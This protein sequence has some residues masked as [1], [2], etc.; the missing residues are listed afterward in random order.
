MLATSKICIAIEPRLSCHSMQEF[1]VD[2]TDSDIMN[3]LLQRNRDSKLSQP[4]TSPMVLANF[5]SNDRIVV[6]LGVFRR[7]SNRRATSSVPT[8][9]V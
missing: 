6:T 8:P 5:L 4:L 3:F 9:S 7:L 2:D 1:L